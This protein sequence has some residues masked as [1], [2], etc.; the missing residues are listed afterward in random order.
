MAAEAVGYMETGWPDTN[1]IQPET[2]SDKRKDYTASQAVSSMP[3]HRQGRGSSVAVLKAERRVGQNVFDSSGAR[4]KSN[5]GR[6]KLVSP[7]GG[8]AHHARKFL[9]WPIRKTA[10]G[11]RTAY[12]L[13]QASQLFAALQTHCRSSPNDDGR[14]K[15]QNQ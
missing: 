15:A 6:V 1:S 3:D 7:C 5:V 10:G 13:R 2:V 4:K 14:S 12:L 9:A 11:S 8:N